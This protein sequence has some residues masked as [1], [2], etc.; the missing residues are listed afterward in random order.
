VS[1]FSGILTL[2]TTAQERGRSSGL[3]RKPAQRRQRRERSQCLK[4]ERALWLHVLALLAN[5]I[6]T[7]DSEQLWLWATYHPATPEMTHR[8][9]VVKELLMTIPR[10]HL[11]GGVLGKTII[12]VESILWQIA[13]IFTTPVV[14]ADDA[15]PGVSGSPPFPQATEEEREKDAGDPIGSKNALAPQQRKKRGRLLHTDM[16]ALTAA[17]KH[18]QRNNVASMAAFGK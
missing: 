7:G 4:G 10:R 14:P 15:S 9:Q 13:N 1:V 3:Q 12:P 2:K 6:E 11:P 17:M 5:G 16:A 8:I 18:M